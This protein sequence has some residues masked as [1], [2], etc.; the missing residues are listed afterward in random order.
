MIKNIKNISFLLLI[1]VFIFFLGN[2]YFSD[3]NIIFTNKSR[4]SYALSNNQNLPVLKNDTSNVIIYKNDLEI[5]KNKRKERI[6]E[7][8]INDKK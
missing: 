6:W 2:Y 5:F 7:K 3:V 4:S 8:L 1:I